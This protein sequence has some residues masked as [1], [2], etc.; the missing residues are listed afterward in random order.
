MQQMDFDHD[1]LVRLPSHTVP[2]VW[3]KLVLLQI[4]IFIPA[5]SSVYKH[6]KNFKQGTDFD[7]EQGGT[8]ISCY[9][10]NSVCVLWMAN[11]YFF[12]KH[13]FFPTWSGSYLRINI[14][15]DVLRIT[16]AVRDVCWMST[17]ISYLLG[18]R[19]FVRLRGSRG[20][21]KVH[22]FQRLHSNLLYV[23]DGI[24][25]DWNYESL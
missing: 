16:V 18:V 22:I 6:S 5:S 14:S 15:E 20:Y 11:F 21:L 12:T 13:L 25:E 24:P 19:D 23:R 2:G 10:K 8:I 3:F 4:T 1:F 17:L 9:W 7:T